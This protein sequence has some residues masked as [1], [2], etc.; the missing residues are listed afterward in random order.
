MKT[1]L[2][3]VLVVLALTVTSSAQAARYQKPCPRGPLVVL[4]H[5]GGWQS[6]HPQGMAPWVQDFHAHGIRAKSIG[7]PFG[8]VI[9]AIRHVRAEVS[10]ERCGPIVTYGISA[11]GTIAAY[12]A[13][14]GSVAGGIN[15][16]GPTDFTRWIGPVAT[17][18]GSKVGLTNYAA[19]REA[20]PYWNL[21]NPSPQLIQ[22]GIAD[23]LVTYD[24][25]LRYHHA[26][27]QS[28]P[29]TTLQTVVGHG[30]QLTSARDS[31]REWVARRWP[32]LSIRPKVF[33]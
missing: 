27:R 4:L 15:V 6:G 14:E 18:I 16:V 26:A 8:S 31:A 5:G 28:Q 30:Q 24:Q 20:S 23:P 11:G 1:I 22:C 10:K 13:A 3:F 12:L 19:K 25:C 7:Y 21:F 17:D 2:T 9:G 32:T 29:D 33:R